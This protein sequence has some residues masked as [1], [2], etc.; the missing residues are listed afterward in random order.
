[1]RGDD[2][3]YE[4]AKIYLD[5]AMRFGSILGLERMSG[6]MDLLGNPGMQI[7]CMHIAGTNGKGST[8]TLIANILAAK[9]LKVGIYTS[10][11]LQRFTERIRVLDGRSDF[12]KYETDETTGEISHED[13]AYCVSLIKAKTDEMVNSGLDHPTEFELVTAAAFIY[14]QK[15]NCDYMILETGL[16]GRLDSTNI[17]KNPSKCIITAIGYDHCDRLGNTIRE[18]ASEKAG[19]IKE[20]ATVIA[21]APEDYAN[22]EDAITIRSVIEEKCRQVNARSLEFV[23]KADVTLLSYDINGQTFT[24]NTGEG[25]EYEL[26]TTMLG[27]YQPMN[28]AMAVAACKDMTDYE[29]I[30]IGIGKSKWP[31][32]VEILRKSNPLVILDGGHNEQGAQALRDTL[33]KLCPGR[34][35][36]I[37]CGVMADKAYDKMLEIILS[38]ESYM[39]SAILC[40]T[41]DNERA[42]KASDLAN[43][44]TK[45]L[46]NLPDNSYNKLAMV[47]FDDDV[48]VMTNEAIQ[49]AVNTDS[50]MVAFG[51]LYMAGRIREIAKGTITIAF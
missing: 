22:P 21:Y 51:S 48:A 8:C 40:T 25:M 33:V 4:E 50:A 32:R 13:L 17:V 16:G 28:C 30:R 26:F 43:A 35:L 3:N 14:F 1:M 18:I 6:L 41:P 5:S 7:P 34:K 47:F 19:I 12:V 49:I 10:P 27:V 15:C 44:A 45:I 9:N 11:Y 29:D 31:G 2:V 46:D 39:I 23:K 38:S 36:V 20:N 24:Y 42:L 37:L